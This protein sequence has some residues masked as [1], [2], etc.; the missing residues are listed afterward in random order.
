MN[1]SVLS[2]IESPAQCY[3]CKCILPLLRVHMYECKC[4]LPLLRVHIMN[5]S[6]LYN[7]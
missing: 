6:V 5:V 3:E 2:L 7:N 1:V 4:I